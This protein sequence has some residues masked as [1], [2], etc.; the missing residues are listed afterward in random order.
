M[1]LCWYSA[2]FVRVLSPIP[3]ML[4]GFGGSCRR[5]RIFRAAFS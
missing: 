5:C 3:V 2:I 4:A 1:P